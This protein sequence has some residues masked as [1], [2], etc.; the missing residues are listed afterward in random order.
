MYDKL[1]VYRECE[2]LWLRGVEPEKSGNMSPASADTW[3]ES[4]NYITTW[5]RIL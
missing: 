3:G 5:Q 2:F 1:A 4:L